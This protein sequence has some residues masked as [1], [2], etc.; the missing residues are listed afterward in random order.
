MTPAGPSHPSSRPCSAGDRTTRA[1]NAQCSRHS[2]QRHRAGIPPSP[3]LRP[4]PLTIPVSWHKNYPA[5][6]F[7]HAYALHACD[8]SKG[9]V[10]AGLRFA[11]LP[12]GKPRAQRSCSSRRCAISLARA[13]AGLF[14]HPLLSLPAGKRPRERRTWPEAT[15]A[16][17]C[18]A[19]QGEHRPYAPLSPS[20]LCRPY[21]PAAWCAR[22]FP[23]PGARGG[24][25]VLPRWMAEV[26]S[27]PQELL[28]G[29]VPGELD[30]DQGAFQRGLQARSPG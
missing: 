8:A 19:I 1:G 25:R 11:V 12:C 17:P 16:C 15:A 23:R 29:Q 27:A 18:V 13:A 6:A 28:Q 14:P 2:R 9:S 30:G 10:A 5:S 26:P 21:S 20:D 3:L 22:P 7:A 4:P 24:V